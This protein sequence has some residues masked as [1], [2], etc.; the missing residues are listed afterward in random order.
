MTAQNK[1]FFSIFAFSLQILFFLCL[2]SIESIFFSPRNSFI[3]IDLWIVSLVFISLH[4]D[5]FT[6]VLFA[7]ITPFFLGAFSGI[8]Y[9]SSTLS[10]LGVLTILHIIKSRSFAQG[11]SYFS[12]CSFIAIISFYIFYFALSWILGDSAIYHPNVIKWLISALT[13]SALFALIRPF[14]ILID[15]FCNVRYPVGFEVEK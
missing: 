12:I 8:P 11:A 5:I 10:F 1:T 15:S 14:L 4:R 2:C 3:E 7:V 13:S 6:G 9:H